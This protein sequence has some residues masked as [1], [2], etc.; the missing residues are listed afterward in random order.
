MP[1][2]LVPGPV[3]ADHVAHVGPGLCD[4]RAALRQGLETGRGRTGHCGPHRTEA[5]A[6]TEPPGSSRRA[7]PRVPSP[8][9]VTSR[10]PLRAAADSFVVSGY[11]FGSILSR[12]IPD[13]LT[14]AIASLVGL[15]AAVGLA[16]KRQMVDRHMRRVLPSAS[17]SVRRRLVREVF[18][19]YAR[20]Y[21]ESFK[22]PSLTAKEVRDGIVLPG[23]DDHLA[24]AL[25]A[26]KGAI[27]A[28]PHL[29]G[30]E[31]AGR[32]FTDR[33]LPMTV[34]VE[35]LEPPELFEWF[36]SLRR[37]FGM[38]VVPL[39]P[40]AGGAV[41]RALANN[42]VVCLLSD[43]FISGS[44]TEVEF[45]GERTLLPAGP[46]TLSLRTGAPLIPAAV[47]FRGRGHEAVVRPA[48]PNDRR[49]KLRDDVQR[50][51]QLLAAELEFLIR[52]A[53]EQW[54]LLQ[55]NWPSDPG[56]PHRIDHE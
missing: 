26:G 44:S 30:W 32:W 15:P 6:T 19:N 36:A 53:P 11:K 29:G 8:P 12:T 46:A 43:R 35:P 20:Y 38:T 45:F 54:H 1:R 34:V 17:A 24:P 50:L 55:P 41:L 31:W 48:L 16:D 27:V 47:Y 37:S 23:Y 49:G 5:F 4:R 56:Y 42:E 51:T 7:S 3:G 25:E 13:P 40:D 39:G 52:R 22:L 10:S 14:G 33:G 2:P 28:L 9:I 18:D 21:V